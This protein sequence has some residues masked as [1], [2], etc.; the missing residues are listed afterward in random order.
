MAKKPAD[1]TPEELKEIRIEFAPGVLEQLEREMT[2]AEL[3]TFMNEIKEQIASG[4]FFT[5]AEEVDMDELE[6][7]DPEAYASIVAALE[8]DTPPRT[9]H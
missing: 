5:E 3:Q 2:P 9:L 6:E 8:N 1:M 4:A 7:E